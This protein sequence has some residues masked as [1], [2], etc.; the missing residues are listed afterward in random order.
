VRQVPAKVLEKVRDLVQ[1][2]MKFNRVP[3]KVPE[4]V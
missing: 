1:S 4:K 3:G 2:Q